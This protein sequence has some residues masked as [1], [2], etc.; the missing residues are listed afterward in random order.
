MLRRAREDGVIEDWIKLAELQNHA[1][2]REPNPI[3]P[4]KNQDTVGL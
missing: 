2:L 1:W 3:R 4:Q